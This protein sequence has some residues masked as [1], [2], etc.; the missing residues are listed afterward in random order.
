MLTQDLIACAGCRVGIAR[1][2]VREEVETVWPADRAGDWVNADRREV[3]GIVQRIEDATAIED[4]RE[5]QVSDKSIVESQPQTMVSERFDRSDAGQFR[6]RDRGLPEALDRQEGIRDLGD[7]LEA[8]I[9]VPADQRRPE[10][11][12][13]GE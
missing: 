4:W 13:R 6:H 3:D 2:N 5:V 7:S 10:A 9:D 12:T 1:H 11:S 8:H